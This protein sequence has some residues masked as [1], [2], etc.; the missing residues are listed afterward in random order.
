MDP[1]VRGMPL[2]ARFCRLPQPLFFFASRHLACAALFVFH[3]WLCSFCI[4][5]SGSFRPVFLLLAPAP[6]SAPVMCGS[7]SAKT[8]NVN[9]DKSLAAGAPLVC[10][11]VSYGRVFQQVLH[12]RRAISVGLLATHAARHCACN[13][14]RAVSAM[15]PPAHAHAPAATPALGLAGRGKGGG[16]ISLNPHPN[17][18]ST[19]LCTRSRRPPPSLARV[20]AR[21]VAACATSSSSS[22]RRSPQATCSPA[23]SFSSYLPRDKIFR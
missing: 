13:E 8:G 14:I 22:P 1:A 4:F 2:N 12:T 11:P 10:P 19:R 23:T 20:G 6:P 15:L 7:T 3:L 9:V 16:S 21:A 5:P 18:D 17:G